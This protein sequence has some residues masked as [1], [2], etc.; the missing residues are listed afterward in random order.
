MLC[1]SSLKLCAKGYSSVGS[2]T[3][4]QRL[5][6]LDQ[7]KYANKSSTV[8]VCIG[9]CVR[10]Y[11]SL[12]CMLA[13]LIGITAIKVHRRNIMS[14]ILL[15]AHVLTMST[16]TVGAAVALLKTYQCRSSDSSNSAVEARGHIAAA[17]HAVK[18]YVVTVQQQQQ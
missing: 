5:V 1:H 15:F 16:T 2:V 8:F 4:L 10:S 17:A 18:R 9:L 13:P 11:G 14:N 6:R 7:L 12:H 3:E